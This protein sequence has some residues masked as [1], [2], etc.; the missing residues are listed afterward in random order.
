MIVDLGDH[1]EYRRVI[2][3]FW[4]EFEQYKARIVNL[5]EKNY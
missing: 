5:T 2:E 1:E 3:Q 4:L